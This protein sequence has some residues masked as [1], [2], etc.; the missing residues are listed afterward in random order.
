MK[1]SGI[2]TLTTDFGTA[3]TYVG[4][5]KG[6]LLAA[7]PGLRVVDLSHAVP[8]GAIATGAYLL[9][10][11]HAVFPP[12]TVHVAVVDPGVGTARRALA[13][14]AGGHLFV[15][16]DNGLL[17]RVCDRLEPTEARSIEEPTLLRPGRAPTFDG[18]DLFA[19]AAA[20]LATGTPLERLGPPVEKIFRLRGARPEI[21]AAE[22]TPI[23]V[24]H[25]D[26]FGNVALDAH[27]DR[28]AAALGQEQAPGDC[29]GVEI[30]GRHV[31]RFLRTFADAPDEQPFLLINSSGYLEIAVNG[32]R[33]DEALIHA[34][35]YPLDAIGHWN[36]IY[37]K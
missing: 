19:P 22:P 29:I 8:P 12:G 26:Q 2:V 4:Q 17:T 11:G 28:L 5:M 16:P 36:R 35:F 21:R 6:A 23:P 9:E 31:S 14:R 3:D 34:F 24:L 7:G 13:L 20:R 27:A 32:G 37:G 18:R 25:V 10:T 1:P 33:A 15:A 30:A